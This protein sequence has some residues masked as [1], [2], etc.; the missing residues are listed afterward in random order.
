MEAETLGSQREGREEELAGGA[1]S[2][3]GYPKFDCTSCLYKFQRKPKYAHSKILQS[4]RGL[5]FLSA[6]QDSIIPLEI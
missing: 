2:H 3:Q 6:S 4:L 5:Q 1:V